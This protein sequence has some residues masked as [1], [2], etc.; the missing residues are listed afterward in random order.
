MRCFLL[1]EQSE[2]L[3]TIS[4]SFIVKNGTDEMI[5]KFFKKIVNRFDLQGEERQLF[6]IL[7]KHNQPNIEQ[8]IWDALD[9]FYITEHSS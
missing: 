6:D 8:K 1:T 2:I 9:R 3:L 7:K 4:F 5:V